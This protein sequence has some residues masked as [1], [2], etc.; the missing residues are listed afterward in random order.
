VHRLQCIFHFLNSN[1]AYAPF[2][3]ILVEETVGRLG[4]EKSCRKK[5]GLDELYLWTT[6]D[7]VLTLAEKLHWHRRIFDSHRKKKII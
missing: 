5:D 7:G 3:R 1:S 2:W 4:T 6:M